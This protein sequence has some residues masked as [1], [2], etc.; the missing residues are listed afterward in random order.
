M[1]KQFEEYLTNQGYSVTT[2]SGNPSTVYDYV[3]R[4]D[5]VCSFENLSWTELAYE[6]GAIVNQYDVGGSKEDLGRKSHNAVINALRRFQE[7]VNK[8]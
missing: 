2:P 6:I 5:K 7:F 8:Q 1:K 3:K 4:I